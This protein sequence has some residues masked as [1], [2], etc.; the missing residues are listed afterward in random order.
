M[1]DELNQEAQAEIATEGVE[2]TGTETAEEARTTGEEGMV[3]GGSE[4]GAAAS[5]EEAA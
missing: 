5:S 2:V 4:E 1:T 3:E